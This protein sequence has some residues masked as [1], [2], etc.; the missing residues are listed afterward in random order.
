MPVC[1]RASSRGES[2]RQQD[3]ALSSE[4]KMHTLSANIQTKLPSNNRKSPPSNNQTNPNQLSLRIQDS[5]DEA[6]AEAEAE[7]DE[8]V[9]EQ[10]QDQLHKYLRWL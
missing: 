4:N 2:S 9:E 3:S 8:T 5:G 7:A 6:E 1:T 10:R